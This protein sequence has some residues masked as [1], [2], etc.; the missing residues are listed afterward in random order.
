MDHILVEFAKEIVVENKLAAY[1]FFFISQA[2]QILFPPYPG[3]M[4]LILEGYLSELAN[5]NIILIILIA[6]SSSLLASI[7]LYRIGL[8]KGYRILH[9]KIITKLFEIDKISTF[10]LNF[11]KYG[12]LS[13]LI[14]K[15][16]PGFYSVTIL[17]AGIFKLNREKV[18]LTILINNS[19]HHILLIFLGKY[20]KEKWVIVI[21]LL[22]K[23]SKYF[24]LGVLIIFVIYNLFKKAV[25]EN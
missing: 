4:I 15:F 17:F 19:I 10:Q 12:Y 22:N 13:I 21:N 16:M 2:L 25:R 3:D 5:L 23:Y 9:S 14:S 6:I 24:V 7:F 18:Y 20:L 1:L 11:K 8:M